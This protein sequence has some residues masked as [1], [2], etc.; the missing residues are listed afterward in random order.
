MR[1]SASSATDDRWR[2]RP[3]ILLGYLTLFLLVF[4]I[5]AWAAVSRIAGA[6]VSSGAL[7]VQGN[8]QVVQH[9]TGGVIKTIQAR[10]GDKVEA[11]DVLIELDGE[12]L[13]PELDTVEGQ[14]FEMLA[15]KSR[16]QA[17]RDQ[18]D[19]ITFDPEL[20]SREATSSEIRTLI[21]AQ[22]QQ[23]A[24]RLQLLGQ[25]RR[26]GSRPGDSSSGRS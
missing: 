2:L 17:E 24:A 19:T 11:G 5:G 9:P 26:R 12:D 7:E 15:R 6:V 20:I 10:D 1:P 4:G 22:E 23:F 21:A 13:S 25:R 14:W 18:L 16:L 8:R 3:L